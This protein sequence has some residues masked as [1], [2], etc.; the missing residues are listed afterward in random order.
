MVN[1]PSSGESEKPNCAYQ[2]L[3]VDKG[4]NGMIALVVAQ[5]DVQE[6]EELTVSYGKDYEDPSL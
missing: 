3:P 1:S 6:G 4:T 5:R 2:Y